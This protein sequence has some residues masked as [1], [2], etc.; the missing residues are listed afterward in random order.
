MSSILKAPKVEDRPVMIRDGKIYQR[1][2]EQLAEE[3]LAEAENRAAEV[4]AAAERE[5]REV[6]EN[7]KAEAQRM[8]TELELDRKRAFEKARHDG[9]EAGRAA[10]QEKARAEVAGALELVAKLVA[11]AHEQLAEEIRR[12]RPAVVGLAVQIAEEIVAHH[13]EQDS[14]MIR[15]IVERALGAAVDHG[16]LKVR[17]HPEDLEMLKVGGPLNYSN[18]SRV[19][20]EADAGI[21]RG[22]CMIDA[23]NGTIDA[24]LERRLGLVRD[25]LQNG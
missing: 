12:D 10:A 20:F 25:F 15:C 16:A 24:R 8:R 9:I 7:A 11:S 19:S 23:E 14:E 4:I 21:A 18:G 13:V 6:V 22:G 5:S 2:Q 3:V 1:K 17:L